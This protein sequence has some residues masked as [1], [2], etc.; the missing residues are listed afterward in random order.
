MLHLLP[1]EILRI[2][3]GNI[4]PAKLVG[5]EEEEAE[6]YEHEP[7]NRMRFVCQ[8]VSIAPLSVTSHHLRHAIAPLLFEK[9][10]FKN[11]HVF[12]KAL[13]DVDRVKR[14][15]TSYPNVVGY[16]R[17]AIFTSIMPLSSNG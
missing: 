16:V 8:R 15:L 12:S 6:E 9:V 7:E 11:S 10:V 5:D 14:A 4:I 17:L 2:I 1:I 3:A 13:K